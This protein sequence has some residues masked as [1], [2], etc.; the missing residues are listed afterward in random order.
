MLL[1]PE[2]QPYNLKPPLLSAITSDTCGGQLA[3][4][5]LRNIYVIHSKVSR[6]CPTDGVYAYTHDSAGSVPPLRVVSGPA[7][8]LDNPYGIYEGQ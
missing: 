4:G 2:Y 8:K 5:Y 6:G 3:L 7:T 1:P